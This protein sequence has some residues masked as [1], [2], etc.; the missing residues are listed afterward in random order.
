MKRLNKAVKMG[1]S[2]VPELQRAVELSGTLVI[3]EGYLQRGL[4]RV[5]G[6]SYWKV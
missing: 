4:S 1:R 2:A 6:L 5:S 3:E